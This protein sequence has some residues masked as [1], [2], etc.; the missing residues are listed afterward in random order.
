MSDIGKQKNS[1]SIIDRHKGLAGRII[2]QPRPRAESVDLVPT[3]V[4]KP[5][6]NQKFQNLPSPSGS[7]PYHLKLDKVLSTELMD[8][9]NN[10]G[11][12]IFHTVGDTGGIGFEVPQHI[13]E[14]HME[15]DFDATNSQSSPAF[16]LSFGRRSVLLW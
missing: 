1:Q 14:M 7:S 15:N 12:I 16:F 6:G 5:H 10:A 9:I 3:K 13:V 4:Q 11:R 8:N 2:Y